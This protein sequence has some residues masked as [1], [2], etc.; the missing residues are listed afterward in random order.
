MRDYEL[1]GNV[2]YELWEKCD[3]YALEVTRSF[4]DCAESMTNA[5]P[6]S[7]LYGR[8]NTASNANTISNTEIV[9]NWT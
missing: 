2:Q 6:A 9:K 4:T 7:A 1:C 3:L 8:W 5:N